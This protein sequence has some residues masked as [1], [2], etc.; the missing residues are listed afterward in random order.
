MNEALSMD[1]KVQANRDLPGAGK[2]V[3][4]L[5]VPLHFGQSMSG[6]DL[7]P[8]A[9]RVAGLTQRVVMLGYEVNDRGDLSIE[10]PRSVPTAGEKLKYLAEVHDAC[11]RLATQVEQIVDAG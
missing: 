4:V 5:G 6:V 1:K 10:R 7:G 8:G 2:S 9:M 3:G 11:E